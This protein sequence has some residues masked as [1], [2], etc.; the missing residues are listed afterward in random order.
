VG[1]GDGT[2]VAVLNALHDRKITYGFLPLGT[3]NTFVRS[4]GLP[5]TYPLARRVIL[6]QQARPASLGAINGKLFANIAGIGIPTEVTK[7]TTNKIKKILGPFAYVVNGVKALI[8]SQ[9]IYCHVVNDDIN[10]HFY[11]H[12]LLFANGR[13]HGNL[14]LGK[15]VSAYN[16]KLVLMAFGVSQKRRHN[17]EALVR[18]FFRRYKKAPQVRTIPFERLYITT[19]PKQRIEAD[20]EIMSQTPATIEIKK[21]AINVFAKPLK[22]TKPVKRS[23]R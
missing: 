23:K 3:S 2:I 8:G 22:P 10:E 13:Y 19:K 21:N 7:T 5:L 15:E 6:R 16:D 11:T 14:P 9:A 1:S 20:G 4:L 17:A 18:L 12:Y